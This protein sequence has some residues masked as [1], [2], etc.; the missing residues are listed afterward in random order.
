MGAGAKGRRCSS[1]NRGTRL[2]ASCETD[3][4]LHMPKPYEFFQKTLAEMGWFSSGIATLLF[5]LAILG[6]V[7]LIKNRL[8]AAMP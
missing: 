1:S 6:I 2:D 7:V 4:A 8:A 5:V 3:H